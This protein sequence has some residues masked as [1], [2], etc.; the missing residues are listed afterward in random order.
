LSSSQQPRRQQQQQ[1]RR[2]FSREVD[3]AFFARD[4]WKEK[5]AGRP[6]ELNRARAAGRA[7]RGAEI[8]RTAAGFTGALN[9][10]K[11]AKRSLL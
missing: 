1:R 3:S 6:A 9:E 11:S 2:S 10:K 7:R 8:A 5:S 4:V